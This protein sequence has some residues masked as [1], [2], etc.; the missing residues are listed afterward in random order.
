M[1]GASTGVYETDA[2]PYI[3]DELEFLRERLAARRPTLGI[4]F[5]SQIMAAALGS[6]VH[7][8]DSVQVGFRDITPTAAGRQS[9]VRHFDGVPV[10]QGHGDTF[11]LPAEVTLLAGSSDYANEAF[12]IQEWALAVQWH[13]EVTA[14][15]HEEWLVSDEAYA[16]GSGSSPDDL[17]TDRA[18]NSAAMQVASRAFLSEWIEGLGR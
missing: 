5:G 9:P 16:I 4:C 6:T 11:T 1:L 15:M 13:P 3:L 2:N 17:R 8:G 7:P 14:E 10:L 12:G 18:A